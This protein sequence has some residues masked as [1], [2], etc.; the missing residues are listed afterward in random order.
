MAIS[1]APGVVVVLA[2][3]LCNPTLDMALSRPPRDVVLSIPS[4]VL[5][6]FSSPLVVEM[7]IS[8]EVDATS[9]GPELVALTYRDIIWRLS[10]VPPLNPSRL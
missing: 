1:S 4:C 5:A 6:L 7:A 10:R 9:A 2:V 3:A 8:W